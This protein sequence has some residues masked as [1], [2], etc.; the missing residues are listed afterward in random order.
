[1]IEA[2]DSRNR[3]PLPDARGNG[4]GAWIDGLSA[5][6]LI[7]AIL[8]HRGWVFLC[9]VVI[10]AA[11]IIAA[12]LWPRTYTST[13][14]FVPETKRAGASNLSGIAAQL[15]VNLPAAD[16]AQSPPFYVDLLTSREILRAIA[17]S[18]YTFRDDGRMFRGR[19][20]DFVRAQEPDTNR[21][22]DATLV[23]LRKR[24][25]A[26]A[27][28]KTAVITAV[29]TTRWPSLSQQIAGRLVSEVNRFN[30]ET[31]QTQAS[32]ERQF[33][34]RRLG[35]ARAALRQAEGVLQ[36]FLEHNKVFVSTSELRFQE[37]RLSREVMT[38][39]QNYATISQ[40][41][42]QAKIDEVRDTPAITIIEQANVPVR[43]DSRGLLPLALFLVVVGLG[44]GVA[45]ALAR[46]FFSRVGRQAVDDY[47]EFR[48]LRHATAGDITHPWRPVARVLRRDRAAPAER[49]IAAGNGATSSPR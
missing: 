7:N 42:E 10:P 28:P 45:I 27:S 31:R 44:V 26:T 3:Q 33:A 18:T 47:Q 22:I 6:G 24:V 11:I 12:T 43:P 38:R 1:M 46:D 39:Q 36:D 35:E 17:E 25:S 14:S 34:E 21:K 2:I 40:A 30:L 5:I 15:G 19:L 48:M 13:A 41:Y 4:N 37:D 32:A 20:L 16:A 9:A 23:W 8:R 49:Q 29:V